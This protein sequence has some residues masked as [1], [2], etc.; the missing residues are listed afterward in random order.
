MTPTAPATRSRGNSSRM[1][2]KDNGI[3]P[4]PTP[5]ITRAMIITV[6]EVA[7]AARIEP[8]A[9]T[10][11]TTTRTFSLPY[12]SPTRPRIGVQIEADSRYAVSTQVTVSC[13]VCSSVW[14]SGRTGETIDCS[15]E[16][17]VAPTASTRK[18]SR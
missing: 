11:S 12:M 14:S 2:P 1:I 10:T 6:I 17:A 9:S 13:D 4:P 5:W 18:V 15:S 16:N 8:R 7:S 3:R